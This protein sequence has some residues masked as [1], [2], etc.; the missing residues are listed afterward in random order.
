MAADRKRSSDYEKIT[1]SLGET[2]QLS[3]DRKQA[4]T[5][6]VEEFGY[7]KLSTLIQEIADGNIRLKHNL[8]RRPWATRN[9]YDA[10]K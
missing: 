5:R 2:G 6:L 9:T 1:I 10:S 3:E 7:K 4:L 8:A